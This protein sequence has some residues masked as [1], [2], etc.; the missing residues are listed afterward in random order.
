VLADTVRN[1]SETKRLD[2]FVFEIVEMVSDFLVGSEFAISR[3][4]RARLKR[5][6]SRQAYVH[7]EVR[8]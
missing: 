6:G 3:T 8:L 7:L 5:T 4:S 1:K 2:Q